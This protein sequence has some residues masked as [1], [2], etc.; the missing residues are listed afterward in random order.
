MTGHLVP[1]LKKRIVVLNYS[2][3]ESRKRDSVILSR[4][5]CQLYVRWACKLFDK[6]W[7]CL[8][9]CTTLAMSLQYALA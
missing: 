8:L 1:S 9:V 6:V 4:V 5:D 3:H 2:H 7:V